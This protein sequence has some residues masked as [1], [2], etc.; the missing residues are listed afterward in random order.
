M[1]DG[2]ATR[3]V[4]P[5]EFYH[6]TSIEAALDIQDNGF[7]VDL[8]GT[9]AGVSSRSLSAPP[10]CRVVA[11]PQCHA[12]AANASSRM[13]RH[14]HSTPTPHPSLFAMVGVAGPWGESSRLPATCILYRRCRGHC[15][16]SPIRFDGLNLY[17]M[18]TSGVL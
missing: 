8:S 13:N 17:P 11:L 6:G 3:P 10:N 2:R 5:V 1:P 12:T 14:S 9:N 4:L 7:R 15:Y 16:P 18:F